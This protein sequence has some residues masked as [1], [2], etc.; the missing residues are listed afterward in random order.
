MT[1]LIKE[2]FM[3]NVVSSVKAAAVIALLF[4]LTIKCTFVNTFKKAASFF[5]AAHHKT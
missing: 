5:C 2:I 3:Q 1:E 4:I